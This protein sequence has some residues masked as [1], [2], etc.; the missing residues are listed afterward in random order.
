MTALKQAARRALGALGL[1]GAYLRFND[2]RLSRGGEAPPAADEAGVPIPPREMMA[3]TVGHADWR[4]F[5]KAGERDAQT[6]DAYAREG[7]AGFAEAARIL[8]LGCGCG[9][10]IRH[11]PGMTDAALFGVD[12]NPPLVAWCND[13]LQGEYAVNDLAP[14]LGFPDAHF[15]VLYLISVFTHLRI[16]AQR[17]WLAE[18]RR[19][20]RPGG[21]AMV[22]FHDESHPNA[23]TGGAAYST[24]METGVYVQSDVAQGS[25]LSATFQTRAAAQALFAETFDI[26]RIIASNDCPIG[27]AAAILRAR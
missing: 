26:V 22:T 12:L 21:V 8:D 10:V 20:L 19:V 9:R 27:Q 17:A 4:A 13:N 1:D 3:R 6:L 2:W 18:L 25:N 16:D 14:R 5:L 23:P 11:L 15:D 7:G 24:L